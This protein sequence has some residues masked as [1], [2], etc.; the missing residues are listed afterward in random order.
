MDF[1][2]F[3]FPLLLLYSVSCSSEQEIHPDV[4]AAVGF[5]VWSGSAWY[6]FGSLWQ[7]QFDAMGRAALTWTPGAPIDPAVQEAFSYYI[8][9]RT[10]F[11][12]RFQ[13]KQKVQMIVFVVSCGILFIVS[14][15]CSVRV[16]VATDDDEIRSMLL[17]VSFFSPLFVESPNSTPSHQDR[18]LSATHSVSARRA[19]RQKA[20]QTL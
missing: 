19:L 20:R 9:I 7:E 17:E 14:R 11:L 12:K 1:T 10:T 3:S 16:E 5:G 8:S 6:K 4:V 13:Y 18:L 2:S 15:F